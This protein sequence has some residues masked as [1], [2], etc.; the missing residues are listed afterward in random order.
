MAEK[1]YTIPV[2]EAFEA[3]RDDHAKGCPFCS[4]EHMLEENELESILG[5]SMME[6]D[7]RIRTNELGFCRDHFDKMLARSKKLPLALI[8]ESHLDEQEKLFKKAPLRSAASNAQAQAERIRALTSSC[9]VCDRIRFHFEKMLD[10]AIYLFGEDHSFREKFAAQ[11]CFC[12]PHYAAMLD[13][14]SRSLSKKEFSDF[15]E[16]AEKVELPYFDA[17]REDVRWFVKKFDY[18]YQDEPW[19]NAKDAV[20]RALRFLQG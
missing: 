3:S 5:A 20:E 18:R 4:L 11:P 17:L 6:P 14:A 9:Y 15:F 13:R 19:N 8:L 16:E 1:I 2:N 10:T 7:I 12:L